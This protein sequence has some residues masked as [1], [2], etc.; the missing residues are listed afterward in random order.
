M[1]RVLATRP[2]VQAAEKA[3][4]PTVVHLMKPRRETPSASA[5]FARVVAAGAGA[6]AAGFAAA[7][8]AW[9][10]GFGAPGVAASDGPFVFTAAGLAAA[11][12][13]GVAGRGGAGRGS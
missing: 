10:P 1:N 11:A 12:V 2:D 4:H 5:G 9:A 6:A 7:L 3:T 13:A 8:A